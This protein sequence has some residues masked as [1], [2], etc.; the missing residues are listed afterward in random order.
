MAFNIKNFFINLV[1]GPVIN[2]AAEQFETILEKF[3]EKQPQT[4]AALCNSLYV[5]ID[6][7]VEDF[8]ETTANAIDDKAVDE[9]KEA[10]E[11]FCTKHSIPLSN[12]DKDSP[13][14]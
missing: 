5:W 1:S 2:E 13:N 12:L 10:I 7:F 11:S 8:A 4:C 6:T 3:Y 14:D 9:F